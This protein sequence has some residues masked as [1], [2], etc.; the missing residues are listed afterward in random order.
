MTWR[1][2]R[3]FTTVTMA[4]PPSDSASGLTNP[5][6]MPPFPPKG[7]APDD[8]DLPHPSAENFINAAAK[9][10]FPDHGDAQSAAADAQLAPK[11]KNEG[12]RDD[13]EDPDAR[14]DR[15]EAPIIDGTPLD[16]MQTPML[17]HPPSLPRV[18]ESTLPTDMGKLH[19]GGQKRMNSASTIKPSEPVID[20]TIYEYEGDGGDEADDEAVDEVSALGRWPKGREKR[21]S[22]AEAREFASVSRVPSHAMG[23]AQALHDVGSVS[24]MPAFMISCCWKIHLIPSTSSG[25]RPPRHPPFTLPFVL[26]PPSHPFT[27]LPVGRERRTSERRMLTP[28]S[29][30]YTRL[31]HRT[32]RS[33]RLPIGLAMISTT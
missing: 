11:E 6:S 22:L 21:P 28:V 19:V 18:D 26:P 3:I 14:E 12:L 29:S 9:H 30:F 16:E 4:T 10:T 7:T 32:L 13:D 8:R 17:E 25:H 1:P 23:L 27:P 31:P 2:F 20:Q 24:G 15:E 33:S 5:A